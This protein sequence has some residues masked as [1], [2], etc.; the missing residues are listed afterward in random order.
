[1]AL[2]VKEKHKISKIMPRRQL[3]LSY[4]QDISFQAYP[5]ASLLIIQPD[6]IIASKIMLTS[7]K[8]QTEKLMREGVGIDELGPKE[9]LID[10]G[11]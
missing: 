5:V 2:F 11:G 4:C 10:K 7:G 8:S 9:W 6:Y 3:K 1:M